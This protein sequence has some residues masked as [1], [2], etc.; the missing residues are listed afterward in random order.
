MYLKKYINIIIKRNKMI[1]INGQKR[2]RVRYIYKKILTKTINKILNTLNLTKNI[3][4][5]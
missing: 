2:D 1:N 5:L 3:I 4:F